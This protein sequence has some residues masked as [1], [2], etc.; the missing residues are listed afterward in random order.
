MRDTR[1]AWFSPWP[2]QRS[3]IAGRSAEL[4]RELSGNG[5][6]IDVFVDDQDEDVRPAIR[7]SPD[8]PPDPGSVRVQ[9]AHDFVWR[10]ARGQYDL[11][12]YQVGNSALHD[13]IW[14]YLFRWPGLVL[15]HDARLHHARGSVLLKKKRFH[16]YREE[17]AYNQPEQSVDLAELAVN[18]FDG[19]YY[20]QWPMTRTVVEASRLVAAHSQGAARALRDHFPLRHIEY[21]AL[22]EGPDTDVSTS[23]A[24]ARAFRHT[25]GLDSTAVVFG[26]LGG[27]T[28]EKRIPQ[29]LRAFHATRPWLGNAQL[30]LAGQPDPSL[31]VSEQIAEFDLQEYVRVIDRLDDRLFDAAVAATDVSLNLRWPTTLE[32]SGPWL[33]SLACG[34][35]TVIFDLPHLDHVPAL[36]PRTWLRHW[37]AQD[38]SE[39]ASNSA[40][41]VAIDILDEEHSLRLALRRLASDAPLRVRLGER[42]RQFWEREHTVERMVQDVERAIALAIRLPSPVPS[43]PEHLRPNASELAD[44]L[45]RPFDL[46]PVLDV[47]RRC[48]SS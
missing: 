20:Y 4:C 13:F 45:I 1:L 10:A 23:R 5:Y 35:P 7:R 47:H 44:T 28:A 2:P 34:K 8:S 33:R 40:V 38:L 43:L 27:L 26:V 36:D 18:G 19:P 6:G 22:G 32:T 25:H 29:I 46:R 11:A 24:D 16:D 17:F 41:A 15:L 37:P 21:V 39:D 9:S 14:P 48:E 3:G 31:R 12:V 42:A 30:L